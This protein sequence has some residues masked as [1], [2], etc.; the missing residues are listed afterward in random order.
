LSRKLYI[1]S[2]VVEAIQTHVIKA[3][4]HAEAGYS[5]AQEEEDAI[6]VKVFGTL[7]RSFKC[8]MNGW[9]CDGGDRLQL[10]KPTERKYRGGSGVVI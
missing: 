5:C 6:T 10:R 1:P 8:R 2:Q 3:M 7:I 9:W 4:K